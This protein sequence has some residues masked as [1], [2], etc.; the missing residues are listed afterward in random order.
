M[1]GQNKVLLHR[2]PV[3]FPQ[4]LD[5]FFCMN[6]IAKL[7]SQTDCGAIFVRKGPGGFSIKELWFSLRL[8]TP[9]HHTGVKSS[10]QTRS[11]S[12]R[13]TRLWFYE[14]GSQKYFK[15]VMSQHA[16]MLLKNWALSQNVI[17]KRCVSKFLVTLYTC[18]SSKSSLTL[19]SSFGPSRESTPGHVRV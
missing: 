9:P 7:F 4:F 6:I 18:I 2:W 14:R 12:A 19:R 16:K 5:S 3:L 13:S 15:K 17:V 10:A 11:Q 1:K 8:R